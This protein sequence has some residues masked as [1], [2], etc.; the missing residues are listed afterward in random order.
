MNTATPIDR[1]IA[2]FQRRLAEVLALRKASSEALAT[3]LIMSTS[4]AP[5]VLW[6]G[7]EKTDRHN[8]TESRAPHVSA[9]PLLHT[10]LAVPVS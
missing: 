4:A 1:Y 2:I 10:P 5:R 6:P 7:E 9:L 3:P 8:P